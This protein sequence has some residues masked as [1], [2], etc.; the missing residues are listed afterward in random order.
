MFTIGLYIISITI[1]IWSWFRDQKKTKT[2]ILK[3]WKSFENILPQLLGV[4]VLVGIILA[5]FDAGAIGKVLGDQSGW[6]GVVVAAVVG[7]VTLIPG[8]VAFPTA[9]L[10]LNNGAGLM[11]M[12][13]FVS[14]LMMVGV[15][16]MPVEM[17]YFGKKATLY[18]NLATLIFSFMVAGVIGVVAR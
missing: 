4:L 7:A 1:L 2:A 15:V 14:A 5:Y 16:T 6:W 10:L 9:A 8:F 13:A 17:K 18:R 11:Q 3:A 12:G